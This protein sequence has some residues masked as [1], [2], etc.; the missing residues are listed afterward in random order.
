MRTD[1]LTG[2]NEEQKEAV[3]SDAKATLIIAGAGTGK[4]H[5]LVARI[6]RFLSEGVKAENILLLTFT[7]AAAK[8]MKARAEKLTEK[9]CDKLTASTYH[10]FCARELRRYC[11]AAGLPKD[12]KIIST[13]DAEDIIQYIT[14]DDRDF[15]TA[16]ETPRSK[17][18]LS[19]FS[20]CVNTG[21]SFTDL[22][23]QFKN[24]KTKQIM[25]RLRVDYEN[26][27]KKR[28]MLDYD[29]LLVR[30]LELISSNETVR[31]QISAQYPYI[32][33]DEY[34]DTNDL[35]ELIV[36]KMLS[37]DS[38][39][40]V[41]GD[42]YQAIYSFR[43]GDVENFMAFQSRHRGCSVITLHKNYRST[44]EILDLPNDIMEKKAD[45]GYPKVLVSDTHGNIPNL[46]QPFYDKEEEAKSVYRKIKSLNASG[47]TYGDIAVL[48]RRTD[49]FNVLEKM[50]NEGGKR[51]PYVMHGGTKFYEQEA[52]RDILAFQKVILSPYDETRW[53]RILNLFPA[54][55]EKRGHDIAKTCGEEDFLIHTEYEKRETKTDVTISN[56][57]HRLYDRINSFRAYSVPE[58]QIDAIGDYYIE[59]LTNRVSAAEEKYANSGKI[60]IDTIKDYKDAKELFESKQFDT[61][62]EL[63][64]G[65]KNIVTWLEDA[66][67]DNKA[68]KDAD[69]LTL[70]TIHSAKGLEW[71][72]VILMD[73]TDQVFFAQADRIEKLGMY[74]VAQEIKR[75]EL[76]CLYVA[77]TRAKD[78]LSIV[79]PQMTTLKN[80]NRMTLSHSMLKQSMSYLNEEMAG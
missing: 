1:Y 16:K 50:L 39:L 20:K 22:L 64:H 11:K 33:I 48:A 17:K 28:N 3:L 10:S 34:Q 54:I 43:G 26:Y 58:E 78:S 29:D 72:A 6:A 55:G 12:F 47:Y 37:K 7:N 68:D 40:T 36:N 53:F 31:S 35:Q 24:P 77:L 5:T 30:F 25:I 45:F 67:L 8:E 73:C 74:E 4:T 79:S 13:S 56:N 49:S 21:E 14:S 66:M 19:I 9:D 51:V 2:L 75:E 69:C 80:G 65:Y 41:V 59:L 60:S 63:S 32:L 27:K 18:A 44:Q 46:D 52:V 38:S 71:R 62:K 15:Y 76:R 42:D 23:R 61:L 57:L 70:S